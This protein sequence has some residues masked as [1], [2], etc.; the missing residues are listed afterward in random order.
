MIQIH[1]DPPADSRARLSIDDAEIGPRLREV[2]IL[3]PPEREALQVIEEIKRKVTQLG[4]LDPQMAAQLEEALDD[5]EKLDGLARTWFSEEER[6]RLGY[7]DADGDEYR[8]IEEAT[9]LCG[10]VIR[11]YRPELRPFRIEVLFQLKVPPANRRERLG[12]AMKLPGKMAHLAE[13]NAVITLGFQS[14][15]WLAD[16]DRQR[17]VHHELEHLISDEGLKSR[18]HDFEDFASIID[19][20]GIRSV[21]ERMNMDGHVG[22]A[23]ERA[24]TSQFALEGI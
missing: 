19:L 1:K 4:R 6:L 7:W 15:T 9:L 11:E 20:Y 5:G 14:W 3:T 12:T 23:I 18:G 10:F 22:D 24:A 2:R 16:A 13:I 21:S 17:L 8:T